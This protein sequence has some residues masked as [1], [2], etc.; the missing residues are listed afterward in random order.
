M[1]GRR[2]TLQHA[3]LAAKLKAGNVRDD[4]V[5]SELQRQEPV[6]QTLFELIGLCR[7]QA[8]GASPKA[9]SAPPQTFAALEQLL[10]KVYA[11][12]AT[13]EEAGQILSGLQTSPGF[14]RRLLAKLEALTPHVAW[15]EAQ[16][17]EGIRLKS[18][19]EVLRIVRNAVDRIEIKESAGENAWRTLAN[20]AKETFRA[21]VEALDFITSN[22]AVAVGLPLVLIALVTIL[23]FGRSSPYDEATPYPAPSGFRGATASPAREPA[24]SAFKDAFSRAMGDYV[25]RDYDKTLARLDTLQAQ[26]KIL[27]SNLT[28]ENHASLL[29]DYYFYTGV[30]H[31]ALSQRKSFFSDKPEQHAAQAVTWLERANAL[32]QAGPSSADDHETYFLG[33]AYGFNGQKDRAVN[34]LGKI[35]PNSS[36]YQQ[37]LARIKEWSHP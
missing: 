34:E 37:S 32:A 21:S 18:D 35:L 8:L 29:R 5:L 30:S 27:R 33:L 25:L 9:R 16:T 10:L 12:S 19:E 13:P 31:L 7:K 28:D 3:E 17:L 4:F 14:Y 36:F 11:G 20:A 24:Y 1:G 23:Q 22:R 26:E 2:P 15:E 6:Y